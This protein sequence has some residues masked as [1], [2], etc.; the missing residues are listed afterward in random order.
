MSGVDPFDNDF[1]PERLLVKDNVFFSGWE[2]EKIT[3]L[4]L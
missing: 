4:N 1:R 3:N 2:V